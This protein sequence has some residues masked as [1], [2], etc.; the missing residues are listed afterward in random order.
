MDHADVLHSL[1]VEGRVED[2][3]GDGD[4]STMERLKDGQ[5]K[6]SVA[7]HEHHAGSQR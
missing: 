4:S 6:L 7:K 3:I 2:S 5:V 1:Q